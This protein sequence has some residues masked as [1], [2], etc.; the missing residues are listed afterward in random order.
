MLF[1]LILLLNPVHFVH[2]YKPF[3]VVLPLFIDIFLVV[4]IES[5]VE[6]DPPPFGHESILPSEEVDSI[7]I[8]YFLPRV[9]GELVFAGMAVS[10]QDI[11]Y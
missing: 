4:Q 9:F 1:L 5:V 7:V 6:G 3:R 2:L 11:F 8:A 10:H